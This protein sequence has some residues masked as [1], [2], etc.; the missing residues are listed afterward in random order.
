MA[1]AWSLLLDREVIKVAIGLATIQI[2]VFA[3]RGGGLTSFPAQVRSAYTVLLIMGL[4]TPFALIHWI[5]LVGTTAMV[6]FGY[7]FLAR[8]LSLLPWN[9]DTPLTAD[10]IAATF[11]APAQNNI[12]ASYPKAMGML[13]KA[14]L[15]EDVV[16]NCHAR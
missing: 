8:C 1:L 3:R 4:W 12:L 5:Q 7:C 16:K 11:L 6:L 14:E 10:R 15:A 13:D 2:P 9:R